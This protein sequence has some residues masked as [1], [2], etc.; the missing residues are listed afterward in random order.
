MTAMQPTPENKELV[1]AECLRLTS[2]GYLSGEALGAYAQICLRH[3]PGPDAVSR[4]ITY[5]LETCE[6]M[7]PPAEFVRYAA[8]ETTKVPVRAYCGACDDGWTSWKDAKGYDWS[9]RC[10]CAA[11]TSE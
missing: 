7:P 1:A 11:V 5:F 6:K 2:I 9:R 10:E 8:A 4:A 3:F